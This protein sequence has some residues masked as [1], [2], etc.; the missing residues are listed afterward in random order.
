[1]VQTPLKSTP[2][3]PASGVSPSKVEVLKENSNFL[4]EPVA[5]ELL[6]DTTHFS[7][8]AIQI[9]KFH[10][11]YQ[12]DNRDNR[13]KGQEKDYRMMLRTR[14]PGG[15]LSPDLYLTLDRLADEYGNG[16]LRATTRQ[17]MQLHGVLKQ[18]LKATIAAIVRSMGSTLGACGDLNR[19]V[20]AP[21]APYKNRPDY[22]WAQEYA[23]RI[24]DLL[25]PQTE[26]YYEIWLDGEK[27]LT[28]EEHPDVV[29]AR[30]RNGNGT[31]VHDSVEPIYGTHYMP[32][33][34][35]CAVTVPG[36][37]SIDAYTHDVTLV[38]ISDKAG[39][40]KGFN[41]LAGGGLGR[42]HNKEETFARV[43]DEIG[44]VDKADVLDLIKAIVATQ[45]DYGDRHNRRHARM[46]YLIHD[47]G[48]D[49]FRQQV[50]TYLGKPLRPFRKLPQWTFYDYL[51]WH[52]QGDGHWFVGV[53]I[54]NG[55][56]IDRPDGLL[57]KTALKE[58]V[59]R[60]QV[61]MLV[62]PNQSVL[63]YEIKPEDKAEI[64]AIL[65]RCGVAKETD[66]DPL[67]RYAMACPALP[68]CGLAVTESERVMPS[69]LGRLRALLT[70]LGLEN[71]HFVVR[72][73]GC[74]NGC[75]RPYM[76]E[77]G[78]VGSAPESYQLWLGGSPNQTRLARPYLER[79]H[80]NDIDTTL[81][82]LFV[83]F[84]DGRKKGESFGDFCDRV[85]FGALR[86]FAATY[87]ADQ[88]T[89]RHT[90]EGRHRLSISHDLFMTLQSTADKEGRPMAQVMADALSVYLQQPK[91]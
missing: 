6:Q 38:V 13:V 44:Y 30:Q 7:E 55:R 68:L 62:T 66:L 29:A 12:Q 64:Q 69:V 90:K 50:E 57:L 73:T 58:I 34:F 39:Q 53:P 25:R 27:F 45:R 56:I 23:N 15:Y 14:N 75:A 8:G 36:D 19:N 43:A 54:E 37:N 28:A 20:M 10:G 9:L 32:R 72:M 77:L 17:G 82:P 89:P 5:S 67:V 42:T 16:T 21:P 46:K 48:V 74:P 85:G 80:D 11:S 81:E 33:K 31:L 41:V 63:F 26:A 49:R 61:P 86:Q 76:A 84:R 4:R 22:Q 78:L 91:A 1:M 70:K 52:E 65:T 88:Y 60:F 3:T 35:K 24:A 40:L 2:A 79:L 59:Q 18:D 87:K 51:G 47:W 83:F 71:E